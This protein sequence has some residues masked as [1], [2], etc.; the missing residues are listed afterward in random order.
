MVARGAHGA[1]FGPKSSKACATCKGGMSPVPSACRPLNA[2]PSERKSRGMHF[3][4]DSRCESSASAP[5]ARV[6]IPFARSATRHC[7]GVSAAASTAPMEARHEEA[8]AR[9]NGL[10]QENREAAHK[11][12]K[13]AL[14]AV[15]AY[16]YEAAL[17]RAERA[18]RLSPGTRA[19]EEL[20]TSLQLLAEEEINL[21][22]VLGLDDAGNQIGSGTFG[23]VR[24]VSFRTTPCA[25]KIFYEHV[26]EDQKKVPKPA[27]DSNPPKT[28]AAR[29]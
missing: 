11:S 12:Y 20:L 6:C 18:V 29:R 27:R 19:Y 22:D 5:P 24:A 25:A 7:A 13:L 23:E 8:Q 9:A 3:R 15:D 28:F 16:D 2:T 26:A 17:R 14:A 4:L 10:Q 21:Q 1:R